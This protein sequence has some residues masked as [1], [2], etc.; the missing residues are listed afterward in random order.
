MATRS[1]RGYRMPALID[2]DPERAILDQLL[3]RAGAGR[4][5][6]LVLHGNPGVGKTALLRYLTDR[7]GWFRVIRVAGMQSGMELAFSGLRQLCEPVLDRLSEL[8]AP[9]REALRTA[10]G[11]GTGPPPDRF[12]V[13]LGALTLLAAAAAERPLLAVIDDQQW[14]DSA[15]AQVLGFVAR[16]LAA[17]PIALVFAARE[18]SDHLTGL[19][20][21]AV[22]GLAPEHARSL[23]DSALPGPV[24]A[25]VRDLLVAEAQGNPLALLELPRS[26]RAA[27]L[28]GGFPQPDAM[29]L[30]GRI[31]RGFLQRLDALPEPTRLLLQLA[32]AD[33]AG[34]PVVVHRAARRLGVPIQA[35]Q[36]A[37][38]AGLAEFDVQVHFRHPLVRSAA[39]RS[40][41]PQVRRQ[42]HRAIADVT[43]PVADP[44]R[45]AWHRAQA[46]SEP[47]EEVAAELERSARRAKRRGGLAA[48]SAFLERSV[49]LTADPAGHAQRALTAARATMAA[50]EF[51]RARA[52]LDTAEAGPLTE[53][54]AAEAD[55]LRAELAFV[56]GLG[57]DA[58]PLLLKAA[59]R[60]ERLDP[61]LARDTYLNAWMAASFA[62][63]MVGAGSMEEVSQAVRAMPP[64]ADPRPVDVLLD[65][66][67][68]LF[69]ENRTAAAPTLRRAARRFAA[70]DIRPED[71]L[72]FGWMAAALVW[73]DEAAHVIQDR[74]VRLLRA[75]GA[76]DQ[77]PIALVALALSEAWRG[78]FAAATAQIAETDAI[79]E[80]TGSYIAPYTAMFLAA[81]RGDAAR[82]AS[83]TAT[84]LAAAQSGGQGAAVT[85]ANWVTAI[86]D[87]GRRRYAAAYEAAR[88]ATDDAHLYVSAWALPEL[89]EAAVRVGEQRRA[90]HGLELLTETTRGGGTD[91][92]LGLEARGRAL[93][94]GPRAEESYREAIDR[95]ESAGIRTEAARAHLLY[96]E[97][98]RRQSRLPEA[99][100]RLRTAHELLESIGMRAFAGRAR[101]EL[102]A[103]GETVRRRPSRT[104]AGLTQREALV[105]RLAA[106]GMSNGDIGAQLFLSPRTVE[107]YLHKIFGK[108][109]VGSRRDLRTA[110]A[111][112]P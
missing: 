103:T 41:S 77:L 43:D 59:G 11:L 63:R 10:F 42:V 24:D 86:L 68:L 23:L 49:A 72:R 100:S 37:V 25:Q 21:L 31:E 6:S 50:G 36:P 84:S 106:D 15:S 98:L 102:R 20:V 74:L 66:L 54:G 75:T 33:P 55:L 47:D 89:I 61:A 67:A 9:Q 91:F 95:L 22:E 87:N 57:D 4:S 40:A 38:E 96:G 79:C 99:R 51:D 34:D 111:D 44:D 94:G 64:V 107:W 90:A 12:L 83:L 8:P 76:L 104:T 110:L 19:P 7:A 112:P 62:G 26:M 80:I 108:L 52:L 81:M 18:P 30:S 78:N 13:S 109:G 58:P 65:G 14:L 53:R 70:G 1:P 48:A 28:A 101:R 39:Y 93:L 71:G 3:E 60:L 2:R 27:G 35:V 92:G 82:T 5:Q 97:W 45:R 88:R 56:R 46:V 69:T 73:D 85:Y 17:D 32:A 29:P 105:A 16:R